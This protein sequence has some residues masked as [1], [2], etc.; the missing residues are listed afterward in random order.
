MK[1]RSLFAAASPLAAVLLLLSGLVP[2]GVFAQS[3]PRWEAV[4][5]EVPVAKSVRL[6]VRLVGTDSKPIEQAFA[7]LK[8]LLRKAA[9]RSIDA[10]RAAIGE[11]LEAFTPQECRNFFAN[12][13]YASN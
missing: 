7:K 4:R 9:A 8:A 1:S 3:G 13:G 12:S 10:L 6:E 5:T 2:T 11:L